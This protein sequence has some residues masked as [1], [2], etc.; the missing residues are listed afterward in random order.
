LRQSCRVIIHTAVKFLS[1]SHIFIPSF[2]MQLLNKLA[3]FNVV[4]VLYSMSQKSE[5][6][7]RVVL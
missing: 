2:S 6:R 3:R 4:L 1:R 5:V 7:T